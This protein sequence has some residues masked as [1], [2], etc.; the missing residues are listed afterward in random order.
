MSLALRPYPEY[1]DSGLPWLGKIP[2]HWEVFRNGRLFEQRNQTGFSNLPI[3][4]VSL[5]TGVRVRDLENSSRKQVMSDREK[6]KR[7]CQGD[8]AYNMMRMWQG[9]VGVAPVDG[10]ISP[11]YVVARPFAGTE[12]RFFTYLFRTK[13]YMDEVDKYSHG[14]VKDRN[15]LYWEDFKQMPSLVPPISEQKHIADFLEAYG[16]IVARLIRAKRRLIELLAERREVLTLDAFKLPGTRNLRLDVVAERVERQINRRNHEVYTPIGLYN[17]GRGI[18]HKGPTKDSELGDST[19]FWVAEGDL[20]LSGQFAWEGAVAL[21]GR[22]DAGCVA[23]HRYPILRGKPTVAES[24][25]LLSFLKTG[26]GH[27][28]LDEHSRGAAGRNRPLN[29]RTLMKEKIPIPPL[30]LQQEITEIVRLER[31]LNR[32]VASQIAVL[33]AYRSQLISDVVTGRLDVRG[34]EL[35]STDETESLEGFDAA[36]DKESEDMQEEDLDTLLDEDEA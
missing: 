24:A 10:L 14:I 25:Y 30:N 32:T 2:V 15:R 17:H 20:V 27:L 16:R 34:A 18:F 12:S 35:P 29:V 5:R 11:A 21:A 1:K 28:L 33:R 8:V 26:I 36:D 19:F 7:A 3:L 4:E 6:Y 31:K 9:A 13:T 22:E 23:S